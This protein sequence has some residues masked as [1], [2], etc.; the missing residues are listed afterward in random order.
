MEDRI[1]GEAGLMFSEAVNKAKKAYRQNV[2]EGRPGNLPSLEGLL[3]HVEI[4]R[5]V[6]LGLVEIPVKKV[7]GTYYH[8]RSSSFAPNF[9]PLL[10]SHTEFGSKWLTV[11]DSILSE[12]VRYPIK[13]YEYLNWYYVV[14]GNKRVSIL[15]YLDSPTVT[16]NVTRL[17]PRWD[18][19]D[20]GIRLYYEFMA[21]YS[22]TG[23]NYV[24]FS[25]EGSFQR[26]L[27]FQRSLSPDAVLSREMAADFRAMYMYFRN[28]YYRC[29]GDK[30]AVTTGDA[31]LEFVK[32]YGHPDQY[33]EE[34]VRNKIANLLV[35]LKDFFNT[36][37]VIVQEK[38]ERPEAGIRLPLLQKP[39]KRKK[40]LKAAF[41]YAGSIKQSNWSRAHEHGRLKAGKMLEDSVATLYVENVPE[42]ME[43]YDTLKRLAQEGHDV[44]FTTS[45]SF[46]NA[47]LRAALEFKRTRF[48]NCSEMY[49]YKHVRTYFGRIYEPRFLSGLLAGVLTK[50]DILGYIGTF[51]IPAVVAGINAFTLGARLVNPNVR[52]LVEWSG[53]WDMSRLSNDARTRLAQAGADFICHHNTY[54]FTQGEEYG[55]YSMQCAEDMSFCS[56]MEHIAVP[57]WNWSVFY[58]KILTDLLQGGIKP[59]RS[60]ASEDR[61]LNYWWGMESGV[62]GFFYS[63]GMIPRETRKLVE[64]FKQMLCDRQ[65]NPFTGPVHDNTGMLRIEDGKAAG[66][67]DI[68][69]MDWFVEGIE[70]KV[71]D[72][73][74]VHTRPEEVCAEML[75]S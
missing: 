60:G 46:F 52:V 49:S 29:G 25:F 6:D 38:P 65:F 17:V 56:P 19:T 71:P 18:G 72:E 8:S 40:K 36:E 54:S 48:F 58:E 62:V 64:F 3:E 35:E 20:P 43:A 26:L 42:G 67:D 27:A 15:K 33:S 53:R 57:I 22:K 14:E 34:D 12:G 30:L 39:L 9:L 7:I 28:A 70:T 2:S 45:P 59:V 50:T 1:S 69:N 31:F 47:T 55:L 37:K 24:W 32:I 11:C 51:H 16:G 68:W 41:V 5:E 21:F 4:V 75:D 23:I 63:A 66:Y 44:V 73:A 74:V 10:D 13:V 61:Y